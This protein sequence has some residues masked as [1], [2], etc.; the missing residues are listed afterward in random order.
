MEW[1]ERMWSGSKEMTDTRN[2]RRFCGSVVYES[3]ILHDV[4]FIATSTQPS[5]P[6]G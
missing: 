6:P 3:L 1:F 2:R 5:I 4:V